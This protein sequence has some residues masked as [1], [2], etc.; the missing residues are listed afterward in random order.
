MKL[1]ASPFHI[2]AKPETDS[3]NLDDTPLNQ[4]SVKPATQAEQEPEEEMYVLIE[5]PPSSTSASKSLYEPLRASQIDPS[6]Y[7]KGY[8]VKSCEEGSSAHEEKQEY[9]NFD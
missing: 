9:E 2:T 8:K 6:I 3:Q 7:A 5:S 4:T 1:E